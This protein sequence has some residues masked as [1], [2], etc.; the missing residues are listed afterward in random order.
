MTTIEQLLRGNTMTYGHIQLF[1]DEAG[2][3]ASVYHYGPEKLLTHDGE[4]VADPVDAL[5]AALIEDDR[6]TADLA[7]RY[8]AAPKIGGVEPEFDEFEDLFG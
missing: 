6:R 8:A 4:A 2:W 1:R 5:R 7:R 3:Q